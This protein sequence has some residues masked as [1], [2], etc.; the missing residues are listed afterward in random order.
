MKN[1]SQEISPYATPLSSHS[2]ANHVNTKRSGFLMAPERCVFPQQ[3]GH[4]LTQP[5]PP[6]QDAYVPFRDLTQS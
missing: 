6:N 2:P 4:L 1:P 3:L 5:P